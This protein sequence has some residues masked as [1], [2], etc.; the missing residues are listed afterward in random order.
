VPVNC[1]FSVE[2]FPQVYLISFNLNI[3]VTLFPIFQP[4]HLQFNFTFNMFPFF[5]SFLYILR[6]NR[7]QWPRGLRRVY[8]AAYLSGLRVRITPGHVYLS[9]V[10]AV[11]Y[12][13]EVSVTADHSSRGVLPSLVCLTECDPGPL[14]MRRPWLSRG[15]CVME[16]KQYF[17]IFRPSLDIVTE[18]V[19]L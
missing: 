6:N 15:C 14:M 4:C 16:K 10:S 11:C 9:V 7:S 2:F 18:F 13:V 5:V 3:V 1:C 8:A 17:V 12:Q 19:S